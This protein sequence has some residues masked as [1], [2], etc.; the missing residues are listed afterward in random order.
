MA[1]RIIT[2]ADILEASARGEK[3]IAVRLDED[4]VT[5][6]ARDTALALGV[7][8]G[9]T[10]GEAPEKAL[11][12]TSPA[13]SACPSADATQGVSAPL[14]FADMA[15]QIAESLR[16]KIPAG[17]DS[18]RLER[19]VREAVAAKAAAPA[20][21]VPPKIGASDEG[22]VFIDSAKLLAQSAASGIKEKAVLA[23]AFG[24]ANEAKLSAAYLSWES[25]SFQRE[26]DA[27]EV[28]VVIAGELRLTAGGETM[29]GKPG[30][31]LYLPKGA[32][33][34]YSAPAQVTLACVGF[35][36]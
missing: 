15:S 14:A 34:I 26:V 13:P 10:P 25:A 2:E 32:K 20:G 29:I 6:Q 24:R 33:V 11:G 27:P 28:C 12:A 1:K 21:S 3:N 22:V 23:E 18:A 17:V 19:L 16:G 9:E 35:Q 5:A 36:A 4:L 7:A 30:D 8:L 31:M